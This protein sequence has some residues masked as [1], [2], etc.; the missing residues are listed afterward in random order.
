MEIQLD[1]PTVEI[2]YRIKNEIGFNTLNETLLY[3]MI[4]YEHMKDLK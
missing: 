4:K 1:K 2:L 3:L